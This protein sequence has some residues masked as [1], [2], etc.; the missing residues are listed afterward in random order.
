MRANDILRYHLEL[1]PTDIVNIKEHLSHP[2]IVVGFRD[3]I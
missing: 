2:K 3:V 1:T